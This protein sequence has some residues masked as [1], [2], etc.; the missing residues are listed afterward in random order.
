MNSKKNAIGGLISS[1]CLIILIL[2]AKTA[3][4]GAREGI[5][6]CIYSIVP[7]LFPF[8]VISKFINRYF[9]GKSFPVLRPIG[10]ICGIPS[11]AESILISGFLGGYPVGAQSINDAYISGSISAHDAKRM[12][13]FC[14][15][16]GP[17]FIF[18]M[19]GSL[20]SNSTASWCLLGVH[21]LSAIIVGAVLPGKSVHACKLPKKSAQN[22]AKIVEESIK[23]MALVCAWVILFRIILHFC[24]RWFLW[25]FPQSVQIAISGGL[26]LANG[27]L[28]LSGISNDGLRF[29]FAAAFLGFG[30]ICVTMQTISVTKEV[31]NSLYFPGKVLQT[32]IS[33]LLACLAQV[34]LFPADER[35]NLPFTYIVIGC[36]IVAGGVILSH[37]KKKIV[38][39]T[40]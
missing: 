4:A 2:D 1:I 10:G 31:G 17:A 21:I 15:N 33:I 20:F 23:S 36:G 7:S 8:C 40:G 13:A 28:S 24:Q 25:L 6:L 32:F 14:S 5:Q 34:V 3:V 19:L 22:I 11:G 16:A 27:C 29:I 9:L 37:S 30:G 35:F 39:F 18:G 38:A 26:E 12:L